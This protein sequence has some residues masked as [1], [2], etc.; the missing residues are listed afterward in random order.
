MRAIHT[1]H[2]RNAARVAVVTALSLLA[3]AGPRVCAQAPAKAGAKPATAA[4]PV[5]GGWPRAS[6]TPSGAELVVYQP[7][8]ASWPDQKNVVLYAAV[9]YTPKDAAKPALGTVKVESA[10]SVAADRENAEDFGNSPPTRY[11]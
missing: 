6:A 5:D 7:Q 2:H 10:T 11:V 4:A 9:S 8:I 3:S 1:I